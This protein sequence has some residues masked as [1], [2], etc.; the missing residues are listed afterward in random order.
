M[1]ELPEKLKQLKAYEPNSGQYNVHLDANESFLAIPKEIKQEIAKAV[2]EINYE[3]YPDPS[4]KKVCEAFAKF[5]ELDPSIV[6]AGNGSDELISIILANFASYGDTIVVTAPDFSMYEFYAKSS[7]LQVEI[8]EK[9]V[10]HF[11]VDT[12]IHKVKEVEARI[13]IFSN[14]CNPSSLCM[15]KDEIKKIANRLDCLVVVDEAYMEFSNESIVEETKQFDNVIVL[16]TCS[17]AFG[18]A[19]LRLGFAISNERLANVLM[20]VKSPYN[21]NTVTQVIGEIV[22]SHTEYLKECI[23]AIKKERDFLYEQ[24]KALEKQYSNK[25][26]VYE[27]STNFVF[28][29]CNNEQESQDLFL[30]MKERGIAIRLMG[31]YVR[32]SA[33]N[34]LENEAMLDIFKQWIEE[35]K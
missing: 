27:S 19:A 23:V 4:S 11:D 2:Q 3:R 13:V 17:K 33:G 18:L 31:S 35:E 24:I 8:F 28:I 14:P 10:E 29:N 5:F 9:E 6:V 30:K 22:L 34:R 20:T 7:G 16:K 12:L 26:T 25:I 32:I 21:V 15:K 1:Y